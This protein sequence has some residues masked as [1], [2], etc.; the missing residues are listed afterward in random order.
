LAEA[1]F[2]EYPR[3]LWYAS[4]L[5][6][7][8]V[9]LAALSITEAIT[10]GTSVTL[11]GG[12][13]EQSKRVHD[14]FAGEDT[15][16]PNSFLG[17]PDAPLWLL[18]DKKTTKRKTKLKNGGTVVALMAS[19]TSVRGPHPSRVRLDEIDEMDLDLYDAASGQAVP[20]RG[21]QE[22]QVGSST[23][24]NFEGTMTTEIKRARREGWPIRTWCIFCVAESNGGWLSE[25]FIERKKN[26]VPEHIWEVEYLLS[27]PSPEGRFID[28][29][30]IEFT[31]DSS[32]GSYHGDLGSSHEF[33]PYDPNGEYACG[34]DWA[35]NR[36]RT[37]IV[38]FRIDVDPIRL[39][40]YE[41]MGHIPFPVMVDKY[42][43]VVTRY[44]ALAAHDGTGIGSV[45]H[46]YLEVVSEDVVLQGRRRQRIFSEYVKALERHEIKCPDI[47]Y[48][49]DEHSYATTGDFYGTG[50]PPDTIVAM[51]LAY[52]ASETLD[53][54]Y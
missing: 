20:A 21:V 22:Q 46:D 5:V 34:A 14:Y 38:T 49:K 2:A 37:I 45:I 3:T 25:D 13:G 47:E 30:A 17:A 6:G 27:R 43:E 36:D 9:L 8:T 51:A 50:H 31:F 44:D 39:V 52:R 41:H 29:D 12:S 1:Y 26:S 33:E 16:L 4:R 53:L 42:N 28:S 7:K 35:K 11:L 15:N 10:L 24:H 40:H 54:M 18:D 23:W 48:M 19:Q 32:F